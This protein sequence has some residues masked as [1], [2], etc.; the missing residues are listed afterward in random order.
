MCEHL[1]VFIETYIYE[2]ICTHRAHMYIQTQ[3]D[4]HK[5]TKQTHA[6][7][8]AFVSSYNKKHIYN[9]RNYM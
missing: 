6:L 2:Y 4:K 9:K 3:T 5:H 8:L 7:M 1:Y